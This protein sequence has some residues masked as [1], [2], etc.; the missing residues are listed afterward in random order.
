M[1]GILARDKGQ[2]TSKVDGDG[3]MKVETHRGDTPQ[4][5]IRLVDNLVKTNEEMAVM[6]IINAKKITGVD[7]YRQGLINRAVAMGEEK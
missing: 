6:A 4:V 1:T 2:K 3:K 7:P 5:M